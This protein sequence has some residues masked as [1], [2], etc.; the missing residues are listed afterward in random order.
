MSARLI[1]SML[2]ATLLLPSLGV[3]SD[4]H[5]ITEEYP[6]YNFAEGEQITGISIDL[7][8]AV[9]EKMGVSDPNVSLFPW[10]RGYRVAQTPGKQNVIFSTTRTEEREP[11]F[12]WVGPIAK[13]EV[14]VFCNKDVNASISSDEDLLDYSFAVIRDDI[15]ELELKNRNVPASSIQDV[16]KFD[17]MVNLVSLKRK[18]CFAYEAN[19]TSYLMKKSG[20]DS[21]KFE[22]KYNL[23]EGELYY[24]FNKSVDDAEVDKH[25]K[26]LDEVR[27]DKD[28]LKAINEKYGVSE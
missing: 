2:A 16:T 3:A 27:A 6:P 9:H 5:Y 28:A 22:R 7:L 14:S 13:T 11:K 12:K 26:A 25:Q 4:I 23:V 18:D 17:M 19:V 20:V 24:A 8:N 1:K 15:G 21:S 10:V